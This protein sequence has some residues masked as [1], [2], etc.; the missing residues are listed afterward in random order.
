M[1]ADRFGHWRQSAASKLTFVPSSNAFS[2]PFGLLWATSV[3]RNGQRT[4]EIGS[5]LDAAWLAAAT[6][7]AEQWK[8]TLDARALAH[9]MRIDEA[10]AEE[11]L[12]MLT[13]SD[14]VR[15]DVTDAGEITYTPRT[16][17]A[18]SARSA[19]EDAF[20]ELEAQ[21]EA[22]AQADAEAAKRGRA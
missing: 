4:K 9:A 19:N 8:G 5:A 18:T 12:A 6:D 10:R 13:V 11:L 1:Q 21:A 20:A 22:E 3:K 15:S 7:V 14:V 16:R 2:L 17:V